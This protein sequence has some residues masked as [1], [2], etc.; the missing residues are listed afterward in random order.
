MAKKTHS[1]RYDYLLGQYERNYITVS[2]LKKWV[3]IN[4]RSAGRG[5]TRDEFKEITGEEYSE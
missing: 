5:I 4:D 3:V 2:T 1:A